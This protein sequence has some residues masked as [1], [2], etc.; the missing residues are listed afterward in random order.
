MSDEIAV[1]ADPEEQAE[2]TEEPAAEELTSEE[3]KAAKAAAKAEAQAEA[4]AKRRAEEAKIV[5]KAEDGRMFE[6]C[7]AC[8]YDP[9]K[10]PQTYVRDEDG[11]MNDRPEEIDELIDALHGAGGDECD[12]IIYDFPESETIWVRRIPAASSSAPQNGCHWVSVFLGCNLMQ[13]TSDSVLR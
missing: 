8:E 12:L 11:N 6:W 1:A 4:Q 7:F 2:P 9:S 13:R 10:N 5:R 3:K